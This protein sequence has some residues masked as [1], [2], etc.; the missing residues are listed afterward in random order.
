MALNKRVLE[1]RLGSGQ[2]MDRKE[3]PLFGATELK[4][5]NDMSVSR[6]LL[7]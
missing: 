6:V 1:I 2:F 5:S 4:L 3:Y 7:V